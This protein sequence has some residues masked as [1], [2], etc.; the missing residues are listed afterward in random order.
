MDEH[1]LAKEFEILGKGLSNATTQ[2]EKIVLLSTGS[3]C[4]AHKY[5]I[6]TFAIAKRHLEKEGIG[7]VVGCIVVPA[8][9]PY[10]KGKLGP[11]KAIPLGT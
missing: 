10:V 4:P 11:S 3:F 2:L 9:D 5:H 7:E 8:S 1:I 6:E